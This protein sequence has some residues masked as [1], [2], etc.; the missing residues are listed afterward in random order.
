VITAQTE[1]K[2]V[3]DSCRWL[4]AQGFDITYL[5]VDNTGLVSL[6]E[7]KAAIRPGETSLVSIMGVN[8][9]IGTVQ[10]LAEIGQL[11]KDNKVK[12]HCDAA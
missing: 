5:G 2:C 3:L 8:N 1:H 10:P 7:L 12:F 11:C 4:E 9:E 6:E